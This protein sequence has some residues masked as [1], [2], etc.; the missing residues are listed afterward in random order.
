MPPAFMAADPD[1]AAL[2]DEELVRLVQETFSKAARCA[3]VARHYPRMRKLLAQWAKQ[4]RL[5]IDDREDAQQE[6]VF[7][8]LEAVDDYDRDSQTH[9]ECLFRSFLGKFVRSRFLDYV[10]TQRRRERHLDRSVHVESLKGY[11]PPPVGTHGTDDP[12]ELAARCEFRVRLDEE[13]RCLNRPMRRLWKEMELG[14]PLWAIAET[15]GLS[16]YQVRRLHKHMI[17]RLRGRLTD[18]TDEPRGVSETET[19]HP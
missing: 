2:A 5:G 14:R 15:V 4:E 13:V 10:R 19:T 12:A 11:V 1:V 9:A 3:I 18:G 7:A 8:L 17:E 6:G 16:Y